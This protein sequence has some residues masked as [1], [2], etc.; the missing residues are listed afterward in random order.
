MMEQF[1]DIVSGDRR[2]R[3][4]RVM[5]VQC[6]CAGARSIMNQA[7]D[8]TMLQH[9]ML[10]MSNTC[11]LDLLTFGKVTTACGNLSFHVRGRPHRTR[12]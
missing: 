3:L 2:L 6:N 4:S 9:A 10:I 8:L 11:Y 12:G 1:T 7:C 5:D